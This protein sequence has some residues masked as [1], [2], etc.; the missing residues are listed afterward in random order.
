[1]TEPP[2]GGLNQSP[3]LKKKLGGLQLWAIAVGMVISGEYFGWNYGWATSGTLGFLCSVLIVTVFYLAFTL[4]YAELTTTI[5]DA[6]GAFA[7]AQ[8]AFGDFGAFIAGFATLVDFV[9]APPAIAMALGAYTHFLYPSLNIIPVAI[10]CYLIFVGINIYGIQSSANFTLLI[11]V[12]SIIEILVFFALLAPHF[13]SENVLRNAPTPSFQ[14]VFAGIP[15]AIWF[16]VAIEGVAMVSEEVKTPQKTIPIAYITAI[17]TLV[18]LALGIMILSAGVGDWRKIAEIDYPLPEALS[19]ALG[20]QND[21]T[22]LFT[23]LGLFGLI[24]SFNANTL[25]Y[26]RQIYALA[27]AGFLPSFLG[28][29][30]KK[31]STPHWALLAGSVVGLT[32]ICFGKTDMLIVLSV[33]GAIVMYLISLLSLFKLRQQP[34][35]ARSFSVPFYP[36]LPLLAFLLGTLC[37]LAVVFYNPMASLIFFVS[38]L[39]SFILF[40]FLRP[41]FSVKLVFS[42]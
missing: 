12:L 2:D 41:Y 15:F 7:Y 16:F 24:A 39:I 31:Y 38:L 1:M 8:K 35:Q 37:F 33:L 3:T 18:F 19:M 27:R 10:T 42:K 32:A 30:N 9:L 22:K 26:S 29:L 13:S 11:T 34:N 36:F 17:L 6:G 25:G 4:S 40:L 28:K 23:S 21:W 5:P 20:K 14:G